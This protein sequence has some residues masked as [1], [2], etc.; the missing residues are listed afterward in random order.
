MN[1][2]ETVEPIRA[3]ALVLSLIESGMAAP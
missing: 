2:A 1:V 3:R